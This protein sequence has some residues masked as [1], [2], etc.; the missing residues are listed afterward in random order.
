MVT[1]PGAVQPGSTRTQ[2]ITDDVASARRM[3]YERHMLEMLDT[4]QMFETSTTNRELVDL[5]DRQL[6]MHHVPSSQL[7]QRHIQL[8][9]EIRRTSRRRRF[10]WSDR[11][12]PSR[13]TVG[14]M[15]L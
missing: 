2:L 14:S 1:L 12:L 15:F 3:V 5:C 7:R 13:Q 9:T 4:Q 8:M 10:T 11:N 6:S